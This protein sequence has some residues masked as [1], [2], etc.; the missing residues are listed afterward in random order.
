MGSGFN[1]YSFY[2]LLLLLLLFINVGIR[3]SLRALRLILWTL[4]LMIM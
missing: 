4:K 1:E 3:V 2:S